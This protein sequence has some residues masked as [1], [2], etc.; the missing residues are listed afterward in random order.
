MWWLGRRK[1]L[2]E[3]WSVVSFVVFG[4]RVLLGI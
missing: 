3:E 1:W 2:A 4:E